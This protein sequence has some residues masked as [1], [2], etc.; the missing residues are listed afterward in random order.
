VYTRAG[1]GSYQEKSARGLVAEETGN[2]LSAVRANRKFAGACAQTGSSSKGCAR[3]EGRNWGARNG[4]DA[5]VV[6]TATRSVPRH[7]GHFPFA[8]SVDGVRSRSV[9]NLQSI[10]CKTWC[11]H[12]LLWL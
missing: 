6:A 1:L 7:S 8:S 9:H 12:S 3:D 2:G 5:H 10:E 11:V 4:R